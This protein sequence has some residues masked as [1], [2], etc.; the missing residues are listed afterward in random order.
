MKGMNIVVY[1]CP[2][3]DDQSH[4]CVRYFFVLSF[5]LNQLWK[6]SIY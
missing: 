4:E 1:L 3:V 6:V 2:Y 5:A